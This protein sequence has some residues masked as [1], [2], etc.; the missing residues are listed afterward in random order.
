MAENWLQR[1]SS[2]VNCPIATLGRLRIQIVGKCNRYSL[3]L[4]ELSQNC[5]A[6]IEKKKGKL[7]FYLK[8]P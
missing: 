4:E 2:L 1:G 5:Q 6:Q 3:F 8:S 7:I